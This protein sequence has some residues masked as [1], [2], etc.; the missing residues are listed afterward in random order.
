MTTPAPSSADSAE[1]SART[2]LETAGLGFLVCAYA[3]RLP[4]ARPNSGQLAPTPAD[5][6]DH[7]LT[8]EI[9]R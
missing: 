8:R 6:R 5:P 7:R 4:A 3:G 9:T 2:L 1:P